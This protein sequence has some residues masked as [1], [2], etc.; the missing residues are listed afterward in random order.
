MKRGVILL[1][2]SICWF[3]VPVS[4]R[5]AKPVNWRVFRL[6]D[7]MPS[8]VCSSVTVDSQG[9]VLVSHADISAFPELNE[10]TIRKF[11]PRLPEARRF[12]VSPAGQFWAWTKKGLNKNPN[13]DWLLHTPKDWVW[14]CHY[15][16]NG[17]T[18]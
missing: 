11:E 18:H 5:A 7:G 14:I 4:S 17:L 10:N 16:A 9:K 8:I 6:A 2:L 1:L 15:R 12:Y 13:G 3:V